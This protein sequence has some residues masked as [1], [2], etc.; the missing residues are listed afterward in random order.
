MPEELNPFAAPRTDLSAPEPAS[1]PRRTGWKIYAAFVAILNLVGIVANLS[2]GFLK[3]RP[4]AIVDSLVSIVGTIGLFGYAYHRA[5]FRRRLWT[6]WIVVFP[7]FDVVM[8]AVVYTRQNGHVSRT[9]LVLGMMMV[10]P[11]YQALF[12]YAHRSP[13]LWDEGERRR[14]GGAT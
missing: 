3:V 1:R 11:H 7:L 10:L 12:R 6:I 8:R 5:I 2:D 9:S 13:E 4:E 14:A